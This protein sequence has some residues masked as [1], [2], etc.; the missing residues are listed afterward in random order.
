MFKANAE[1][2]NDRDARDGFCT[3]VSLDT[4]TRAGTRV[5]LTSTLRSSLFCLLCSTAFYI[6]LLLILWKL[7][8]NLS[9]FKN[10]EEHWSDG[11]ARQTVVGWVFSFLSF[12]EA[13]DLLG[14]SLRSRSF[15]MPFPCLFNSALAGPGFLFWLN[16]FLWWIWLF[17]FL[18]PFSW[19]SQ[20]N[21]FASFDRIRALLVSLLFIPGNLS[22]IN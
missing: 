15:L 21:L 6:L 16:L 8:K 22:I 12:C 17:S 11:N 1:F 3:F 14:L 10:G 4:D 5:T 13:F 7:K 18:A 20:L 9:T 2:E 19:K